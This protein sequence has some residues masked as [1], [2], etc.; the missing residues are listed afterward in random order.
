ML[1]IFGFKV[2]LELG[3]SNC[4]LELEL[5]LSKVKYEHICI[6]LH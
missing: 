2:K 5:E 6:W 1:D 4:I 3:L